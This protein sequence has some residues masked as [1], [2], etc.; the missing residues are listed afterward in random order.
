[1]AKRC[2]DFA[3]GFDPVWFNVSINAVEKGASKAVVCEIVNT[4]SVLLKEELKTILVDMC[5]NRKQRRFWA[6]QRSNRLG[7]SDA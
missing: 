4:I 5:E 7:A 3:R 1:V 2:L 6:R